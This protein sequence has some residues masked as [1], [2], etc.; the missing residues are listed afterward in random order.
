M[1]PLDCTWNLKEQPSW[2]SSDF[3][4][5]EL[6]IAGESCPTIHSSIHWYKL[7]PQLIDLWGLISWKIPFYNGWSLGLSIPTSQESSIDPDVSWLT[8]IC[9]KL[10]TPISDI[11]VSPIIPK[12][13]GDPLGPP[14]PLR[15]GPAGASTPLVRTVGQTPKVWSRGSP[16]SPGSGG[17]HQWGYPKMDGF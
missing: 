12:N 9:I 7:R 10:Y 6:E 8:Q 16:G 15:R 3:E 13:H 1:K 4:M 5:V 14:G 2:F 17:V 11:V